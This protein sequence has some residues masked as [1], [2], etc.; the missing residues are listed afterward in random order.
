MPLPEFFQFQMPTTVMFEIGAA[1]QTGL[2]AKKLGGTKAL[3]VTDKIIRGLGLPD[4]IIAGLDDAGVEIALVVDDVP[5]DSDADLVA[6]IH[7]H[8]ADNGA[9]ICVAV[10]GGSVIDTTKMVNLLLTEGG[11]L[12]K[13]HQGA[14]IQQRPIGPMIA[15]PTT[16][17][18]GSEV[19]FAAVIKDAVNK[20]KVIFVSQHF[21]PDVAILDPETN[22][23][24][25]PGVTAGTGMDAL[26]HAIEALYSVQ[27]QPLSDGLALSAIRLISRSL[28]VAVQDGK[29]IA[30]RA[31]M[32]LA[33]CAAGIAFTNA[34]L[35]VVHALAH[36]IG[37]IAG[38]PHGLANAVILPWGMEFNF[39]TSYEKYAL[40]AHAMGLPSSG[41]HKKDAVAVID[42]VREI[43]EQCGIPSKLSEVGVSRDMF[44]DIA[45]TSL[46]DACVFTNP[47]PLESHEDFLQVL[48]KAF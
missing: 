1:S 14:Y 17:G 25:P 13:D 35:G 40:A 45:M 44:E 22:V 27:A 21:A 9:D 47:R 28:P 11:D 32:L 33:A 29:D 38:T 8:A 12:M 20:M 2:E 23:S 34:P 6:R 3:L 18:T 30:A 15:I 31:D 36:S 16:A 43:N 37:G 4:K 26:T 39:D 46:G 10:G 19:T 42:R 41:D 48:E 7:R 24:M 5:Q